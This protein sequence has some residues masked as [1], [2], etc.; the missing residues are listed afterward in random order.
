[1]T[2]QLDPINVN[3]R[4]LIF[5]R[6]P[7]V[8]Y[9]LSMET[10]DE[11]PERA[12]ILAEVF[13]VALGMNSAPEAAR[14]A[15]EAK[16]WAMEHAKACGA[17]PVGIGAGAGMEWRL[18]VNAIDALAALS[19][20]EARWQPMDTAPKVV[21]R[22]IGSVDGRARFICWGKTSHVPMYGWILTD[23]GAEDADLCE[24]DGWMELPAAMSK[25]QP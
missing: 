19:R 24:P 21:G 9:T 3:V 25:E 12:D 20:P 2:D 18:M 5:S 11:I 14:L 15:E 10:K 1:M 17:K 16:K 4:R 13:R 8:G 7:G 23:Q 22:I 6:V